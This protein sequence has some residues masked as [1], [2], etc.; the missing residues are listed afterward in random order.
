MWFYFDFRTWLE[1]LRLAWREQDAKHR[2]R[3]LFSLGVRVPA[4]AA[5]HAVCF[6]LDPILFPGLRRTRVGPFGED[7]AI[8]LEFLEELSHKA[9]CSEALPTP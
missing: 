4:A 8:K 3:L 6:F 1:M 2:R 7:R 9:G 5:L